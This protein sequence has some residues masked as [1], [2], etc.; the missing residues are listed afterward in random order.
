M[1]EP[2]LPPPPPFRVAVWAALNALFYRAAAALRAHA[3]AA[4]HHARVAVAAA[5]AR[6]SAA[7]QA[8]PAPAPALPAGALGEAARPT[9]PIRLARGGWAAGPHRDPAPAREELPTSVEVRR[10]G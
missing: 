3:D 4:A 1:R 5:K 9:L 6:I 7:V 8:A 2:I 10:V